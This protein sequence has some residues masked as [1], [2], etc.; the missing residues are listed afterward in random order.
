MLNMDN[1]DKYFLTVDKNGEENVW[2]TQP[3]RNEE[4]NYWAPDE[5]DNL[6]KCMTDIGMLLPKGRIEELIGKKLTWEDEPY[7]YETQTPDIDFLW[8]DGMGHGFLLCDG[9]LRNQYLRRHRPR[10]DLL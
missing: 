9:L 6:V 8:P 7:I 3:F 5:D 1:M 2:Y 4:E 10:P